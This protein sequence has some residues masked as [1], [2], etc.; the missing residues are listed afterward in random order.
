[1]DHATSQEIP[2]RPNGFLYV[3]AGVAALGGLLFGYDTGV[4]SGAILFIRQDYGLSPL[5]VE[6]VVSSVLWGAVVG[7]A[8]GG[9]LTDRLGRRITLL[10]AGALFALGAVG[11][12]LAPTVPWLV[13][14]RVMVGAAI[15][16]ASFATPLYI[17]EISPASARG[18]LVSLNQLAITGGILVSYLVDYAL[19]DSGGWRW[20][21]GLAA[22]PAAAL[23]VGMLLLPESP[24]WLLARG[25]ADAARAV[26]ERCRGGLPVEAELEDIQAGLRQRS[27][28]WADLFSPRVRPALVVGLGL[29]VL[30]QVSGIN[31]VI[32]YAPTIFQTAGFASAAA[33]ILATVG[34]GT[35]NVLATVVAMR[36][37][38]RVGRRPLLLAS[39]G[40]MAASLGGLALT[41]AGSPGTGVSGGLVVACLMLYVGSFAIGMGPVFWLLIA[42]IYPL[43]VRGRAMS[44]ATLGNWAAN[45]IVALTFLSLLEGLGPVGT[46]GLYALVSI[47]GL[48]FTAC[49]VPETKGRSLEEI[50]AQWQTDRQGSEAQ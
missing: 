25:S 21:L 13:V 35:V 18:A 39:L 45:L 34:V 32:Y 20:M 14:G 27:G 43:P 37:V 42:E 48:V 33:A 31:T 30:Q 12:A 47:G 17:S 15:G 23:G 11:T 1:M 5:A 6:V 16:T 24:R 49:L 9:L 38:D 40:G 44:V 41:F 22:V 29:A 4:I 28:T 36:L 26:L 50:E 10:L 2:A 7:A 19:A 46:F 3:V 8:V